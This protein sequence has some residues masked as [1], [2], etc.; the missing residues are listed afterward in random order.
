MNSRTWTVM[1]GCDHGLFLRPGFCGQ[2][3]LF[4]SCVDWIILQFALYALP[5]YVFEVLWLLSWNICNCI[6]HIWWVVVSVRLSTVFTLRLANTPF[7]LSFCICT[8]IL[9]RLRCH[10]FLLPVPPCVIFQFY[11]MVVWS[12]Y[13]SHFTLFIVSHFPHIRTHVVHTLNHSC[14]CAPGL[15][16]VECSLYISLRESTFY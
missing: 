1:W 6:H 14:W 4:R 8:T 5:V 9:L 16:L 7:V 13:I 3:F 11:S 2:Y 15:Q 12:D 10:R